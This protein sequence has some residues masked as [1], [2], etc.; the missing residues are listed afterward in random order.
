MLM[1]SN[2]DKS[3]DSNGAN[4]S[5]EPNW[6]SSST[7]RTLVNCRRVVALPSDKILHISDVLST[8]CQL[9][10]IYTPH[11]LIDNARHERKIN[12]IYV[13]YGDSRE[14]N[15]IDGKYGALHHRGQRVVLKTL[16]AHQRYVHGADCCQNHQNNPRAAFILGY[17]NLI[18]I[19]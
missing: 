1:E 16:M 12:A 11:S 8:N 19:W 17:A 13:A 3:S 15:I 5:N 10:V 9:T 18:L 2:P 4:I 6:K 14:W 7:A